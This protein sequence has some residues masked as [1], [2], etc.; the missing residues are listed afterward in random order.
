MWENGCMYRKNAL[1][2]RKVTLLQRSI[3]AMSSEADI[4]GDV[5]PADFKNIVLEPVMPTAVPGA[6]TSSKSEHV[7][8]SESSID[9]DSSLSGL[10][11]EEILNILKNY[12]KEIVGEEKV[13][14]SDDDD[15]SN[16]ADVDSSLYISSAA[17]ESHSITS[18]ELASESSASTVASSIKRKRAKRGGFKKGFLKQRK[19]ARRRA[20][21]SAEQEGFKEDE[22]RKEDEGQEEDERQVEEVFDIAEEAL[23]DRI[24]T[25]EDDDACTSRAE[26]IF[27]DDNTDVSVF[28]PDTTPSEGQYDDQEDSKINIG[29]FEE[30]VEGEQLQVSHSTSEKFSRKK[31]IGIGRIE[32][33]AWRTSLADTAES[34][35]EKFTT[36]CNV[37]SGDHA[38]PS[39]T[40]DAGSFINMPE[41][42]GTG[43][44]ELDL[45][46]ENTPSAAISS[47]ESLSWIVTYLKLTLA[48]FWTV[49]LIDNCISICK[50]TNA[51]NPSVER[52]LTWNGEK[53]RAS[54]LRKELEPTHFF[55]KLRNK[56]DMENLG[57]VVDHLT[58]LCSRLIA[59][60]ICTGVDKHQD[61]WNVFSE[62][63]N[64]HPDYNQ[65]VPIFRSTECKVLLLGIETCNSCRKLHKSMLR[66]QRSHSKAEVT[67]AALMKT[68]NK[69]LLQDQLERKIKLISKQK[70]MSGQKVK[71]L[72]EKINKLLKEKS[73][74]VHD[75]LG[76]DFAKILNENT[77]KMSELE[78]LF[79]QQQADALKR[80]GAA[81]RTMRWHPAMIRLALHLR[82]LSPAAYDYLRGVIS[83]P[84]Q[85]RLFDYSQFIDI[86]EGVQQELLEH[87][88][89]EIEKKC[90]NKCDQYFS[91][92]LDEM[93]IR[94]DLVFNSR[95]GDL[96][97]Y[98]NL[99]S[100][101]SSMRELEAEMEDNKY[102]KKLAKK[103]LVFMLNGAT[104]NIRF[105]PAVFSTDDLS[106]AQLYMKT[107]DIIYAVEEAGAK[108]LTVIFDGASMNKKF[109]SMNFNASGKDLGYQTI[110]TASGD[111]RKLFFIFDPPHLIKT[112]RNCLANSYSHRLSRKL[113]KDDQHLSWQ[114]IEAL[115]DI[116]KEHKFK[117][118]KLTKAHVKLTSFSCMKV[119]LA[120]QVLSGSVADALVKYK[121][122]SP[123]KKVYSE[124]L[125]KLI[126]LVNRTFDC[127]NGSIG[128]KKKDM[129]PDLDV[130]RSVADPRFLFLESEFLGF[131]SDWEQSISR[132]EGAFT[133]DEK[134][135]M[136]ISHQ[137]LEGFKITVASFVEV[138]KFL[139]LNGAD[140]VSAR[141][142]NQ[143]PLEQYFSV[144]RRMRGSDDHPNLKQ[145]QHSRL[146]LQGE[147]FQGNLSGARKGNTETLKRHEDL[148]DDS[149][150][151]VR[152]KQKRAPL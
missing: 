92:L 116:T 142:F 39:I 51:S 69:Y 55:W 67:D 25:E 27:S 11:D 10:S 94:S 115:Y 88:Q 139:L 152:K 33:Y 23:K 102:E 136:I 1:R 123:L 131:L 47:L 126:R 60:K 62:R 56:P 128:S 79:R 89:H 4:F 83:L 52:S 68:N 84:S 110:N 106:A 7:D 59:F 111:S 15:H 124:E 78:K 40:P 13:S 114:A 135:R 45:V 64:G 70:K 50:I 148:I 26:T 107:W 58:L 99:T 118:T 74:N 134:S 54:V 80:R 75:E 93:S 53:M 61:I 31:K 117:C 103:V 120:T 143:D 17:S 30:F 104:K 130:Y 81:S 133:K 125:V 109:I 16:S 6:E 9:L 101:E 144:I 91:L 82:M 145:F 2:Y 96:V 37:N 34:A 141:N 43:V 129:N 138:I 127:F 24:P 73:L 147:L 105:V 5:H 86:Q 21:L 97:G 12:D 28:H 132:R 42:K 35:A 32:K 38:H 77:D 108:V 14:D 72:T 137:T 85:R 36:E 113:W 150:L 87:L 100:L 20:C 98:T 71:R 95:T 146:H 90:P 66:Y 41:D 63:K 8:D 3:V 122:V 65:E 18:G 44:N 112:F 22:G 121:D 29:N 19:G 76:E 119:S 151:P 46:T 49:S 48:S 149:P 140:H 57:A